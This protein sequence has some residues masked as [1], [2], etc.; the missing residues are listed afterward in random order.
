MSLIPLK[1]SNSITGSEFISNNINLDR[2]TREQNILN[3]FLNGNIPDFLRNFI[4]ITISDKNNTITYLTTSDY[5]SIG[6]DNDY[7]RM[8]MMPL[9]AQKIADQY[10]CTLPT[11][12]M[13]L[14]IWKQ[15]EYKLNPLP[16]PPDKEMMSTNRFYNHN[17]K[18]QN[19]IINKDKTKLISGH[20]KDVV[21]TNKLS[22]N[23]PNNRVAIYGWIKQNGVPIQNLNPLSHEINYSDYAHGIRLIAND[24]VVNGLP[25][26]IQ[27]IFTDTT[28]SALI[29]D[30]GDSLKFLRY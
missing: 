29:N 5:L 27:D 13:V 19:Q 21:L 26:R 25:T 9:T 3:E 12:K 1:K 14:D 11:R 18:I 28:L 23:N 4:P 30:E 8:P 17:C 22:P 15:S 6:S 24:V 10:D 16:I 20:K 7:V 2:M